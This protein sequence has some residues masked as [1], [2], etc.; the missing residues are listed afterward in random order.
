MN[1]DNVFYVYE[2]YNIDTDEVFYVGKGKDYRYKNTSSRNKFFKNYYN[3][4]NCDVRIIYKNLS[5]DEAFNKEIETIKYYKENTNYRLTNQTDGG[6]GSS[7]LIV[8]DEFREIRQMVLGEK[9]PNY[10]HKWTKEMK[11]NLRIKMKGRYIGEKNPNYNHKWT[12]EQKANNNTSKKVICDGIEFI[13]LK[14]CS[15][16][17]NINYSTMQGWVNHRC[18]MPKEFEQKGLKW[19][20]E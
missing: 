2:W 6:E 20:D 10:N 8:T 5:E 1:Q 18:K 9:N 4:H 16:F 3:T 17:Y 15:E 7:G 12:R 13:T 19:K 14:E 11:E